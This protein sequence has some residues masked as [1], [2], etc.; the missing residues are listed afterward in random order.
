VHLF[1]AEELSAARVMAEEI[2]RDITIRE[3]EIHLAEERYATER[4]A[5]DLQV[6]QEVGATISTILDLDTMLQEVVDLT[7]E[8]FQLYHAH[9]YLLDEAEQSLKLTAG[10]GDAGRMMKKRGH[11]ISLNHPSSIVARTARTRQ[12][13]FVNDVTQSPDFLPNPLLP[14]TRSE[15]TV[16]MVVNE[17]LVGVLDV[18]SERVGRFNDIDVSTKTALAQ[19]IAVAVENARAFENLVQAQNDLALTLQAQQQ[20]EAQMRRRASELETVGIVSATISTILNSEELLDTVADLTKD[21]FGL[22]HAHIYLLDETRENLVLVAG[23]GEPGR[24]MKSR[25]HHIPYNHPNS[26]V[27][28]TAR[29]SHGVIVNDVTQEPSFLPN[30]LLPDTRSEMVVPLIVG[31]D[32][33]GV[34]DVQADKVGHFTDDDMLVESTLAAQIAVA[35]QNARALEQIILHERAMENSSSG[36]TIADARKPGLPII[37]VNPAFEKITG[38]SA[39]E[40]RGQHLLFLES[41]TR[42]GHVLA[43]LRTMMGEGEESLATLRIYRKDGTEF[44]DELSLSPIR[45]AQGE[46]THYV[47]GH[48]DITERKDL[49]AQRELML[50]QVEEQAQ[51]DRETAER[52]LDVDRLKSQFLANMSHELRTPLNSIIGYSEILLD[53]DDGELNEDALED[54]ETI[55][56][57]GRHLLS[58]INEILDLAK[59]ESGQLTLDRRAVDLN[60]VV[61]EVVNTAQ[62]LVKGKSVELK[63]V[64]ESPT[65]NVYADVIRLRQIITNLVSNAVKFTEQGSV[66][67]AFGAADNFSAYVEVRDTGIGM[68]KEDLEVIFQQFQQVDG[69]ATRR[70]GGTGLGLT[71]TRHLVDL[72]EGMVTVDSEQGVGSTFRVVLPLFQPEEV[73]A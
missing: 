30:P 19:E 71:I 27:A 61:A 16:P 60:A 48:T 43:D 24:I 23:A 10:A 25:G 40:V 15:N 69:S 50:R 68:K 46:V 20:A 21:S 67:V 9:I 52:L 14:R 34:L 22:Y 44:W 31:S 70:A 49:E 17:R 12:G 3:A 51:R 28:R 29:S 6:V 45:N 57:S 11:S 39:E 35:V 42:D 55:H 33:I 4:L 26:L 18:Q 5:N 53:G 32:L 7:K 66:T 65:D 73:S 56:Q 47:G 62:V 13:G 72:H 1:A 41:N 54:V 58:I 36:L 37:Y 59:I 38:Y 2:A 63:A 64:E 8:R